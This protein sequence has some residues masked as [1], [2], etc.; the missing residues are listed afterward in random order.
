MSVST[1]LNI[2]FTNFVETAKQINPDMRQRLLSSLRF[3]K[4][5]KTFILFENTDEKYTILLKTLQGKEV[6]DFGISNYH[7]GLFMTI[8]V[9]DEHLGGHLRNQGISRLMIAAMVFHVEATNPF[10]RDQLLFIDVDSSFQDGRSFWEH[11]G[12]KFCRFDETKRSGIRQTSLTGSG[13]EKVI[14]YSELSQWA[15]GVPNGNNQI[16]TRQF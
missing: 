4:Q 2:A 12:M 15:I 13:A 3:L 9:D 10:R 16:I 11:I 6:G 14:T 1:F 8:Y 7:N 5:N